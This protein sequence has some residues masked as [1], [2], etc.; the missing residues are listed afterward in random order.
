MTTRPT[1]ISNNSDNKSRVLKGQRHDIFEIDFAD[2]WEII[3]LLNI[4]KTIDKSK[5]N[6]IAFLRSRWQR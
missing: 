4:K 5:Q 1:L 3:L 2:T 6:I